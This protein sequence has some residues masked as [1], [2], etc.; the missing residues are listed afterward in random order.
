MVQELQYFN[1]LQ[2]KQIL[3]IIYAT[4]FTHGCKASQYNRVPLMRTSQGHKKASN[5]TNFEWNKKHE[6]GMRFGCETRPER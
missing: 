1:T 3:V 4:Q 5:K 2:L 6:K